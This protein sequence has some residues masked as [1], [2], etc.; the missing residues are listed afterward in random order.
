MPKKTLIVIIGVLVLLAAGILA[1]KA[2]QKKGPT[3]LSGQPVIQGEGPAAQDETADWKTFKNTT[4]KYSLKYPP[5]I[6][7]P[8]SY[9]GDVDSPV[10]PP[11]T[12][13]E[14]G[15]SAR[16][17][18]NPEVEGLDIYVL[19]RLK[20]E[21]SLD[22][23]AND[24]LAK[25][26]I[27]ESVTTKKINNTESRTAVFKGWLDDYP[28]EIGG[29]RYEAKTRVIFI[30][31]KNNQILRIIYPL[32]FCPNSGLELKSST[33]FSDKRNELYREIVSTLRIER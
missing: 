12:C 25:S 4:Y 31:L 32:E 14:V 2:W 7:G 28:G 20:K 23:F 22:A 8:I 33:C 9:C 5:N 13:Y 18:D 24:V 1:Y 30:S 17:G 11:E 19:R 10:G 3:P 15:I 27:I 29:R 21:V 26:S 16:Q 6:E